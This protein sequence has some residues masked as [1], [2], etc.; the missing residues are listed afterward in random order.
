MLGMGRAPGIGIDTGGTFTDLVQIRAGRRYVTKVPST[1]DDPARAVLAALK[2]AGGLAEGERLHHGS[3]VGTN[4]VLTKT[5]AEVAFVT[6]AGFEDLLHV[7]R[8]VEER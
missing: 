5:G 1:P 2:A 4:A 3:T 7:G 6:T 8:G